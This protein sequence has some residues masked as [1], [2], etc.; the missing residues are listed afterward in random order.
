MSPGSLPTGDKPE[1]RL[2]AAH[3]HKRKPSPEPDV[4][5]LDQAATAVLNLGQMRNHASQLATHL[6]GIR[7]DL[8]HRESELNSRTAT[9]ESEARAARLWLSYAK[10]S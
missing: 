3:A 10:A 9:T 1:L 5:P 6:Q 2:D 4:Q 7:Q 8:D